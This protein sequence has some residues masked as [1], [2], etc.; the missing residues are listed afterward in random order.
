MSSTQACWRSLAWR[1]RAASRLSWRSEASRSS[2]RASHSAWPRL[3]ASP[4]ASMSA[5][6]LAM[7]C[8][9]RALSRSWVGWVSKDDLLIVVA[10]AA[11]V[12]MQDRR[13]IRG[14]LGSGAPIEVVGEDRLD[15]AIAARADVDCARSRGVE[16]L[17]SIGGGEPQDAEAG[18][19]ALL[20]VRALVEDEVAQ[21]AGRRADRGGVL[22]D[23]RD[24]PAGVAA[25][26]RCHV[27]RHG[28]VLV[29]AAH[30]LM[31]GDPLA[32]V[33]DLDGAGGEPHLDLGAH[34][35]MR[36][37]VVM[38]LDLDVIVEAHAPDAPLGEH[39]GAR[40]QRLEC[41]PVDLLQQLAAGHAEP[42]D[43]ALLVEPR[44]QPGDRRVD[45]GKAVE[46]A[47]T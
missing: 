10:R 17:A 24:G 40:R 34:E 42:A 41:R 18:A 44:E 38:L 9:P 14:A 43:R 20:R 7:P 2:S 30:A 5:K 11:D 15:R 39:V 26:A 8:R 27:L 1:R 16:P 45:V 46:D 6:A 22:A 25:M 13:V 23:A 4:E 19:E 36:D 31:G 32:L 29:I 37:A 3:A 12:G 47:V 28:G 35:A 33:E 21:R